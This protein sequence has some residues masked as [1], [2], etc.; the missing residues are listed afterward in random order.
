MAL[1]WIREDTPVWDATKQLIVGGTPEG[2]LEI[3]KLGLGDLAPGEWFRVEEDGTTVGYGWMD[4]TWGDAEITLAV[5]ALHQGEGVG[6][7]IVSHLAREAASRGVNYLYNAVRPT[8]PDRAG[9][10]RWLESRGFALSGDG[11]LKRRVR[12]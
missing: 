3:P 7:F 9:V 10:T 12:P 8:H 5:D 4:C 1:T 11:L 2:A 6:D